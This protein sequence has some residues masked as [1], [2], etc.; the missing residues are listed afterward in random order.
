MNQLP[1]VVSLL[2]V[3]STVAAQTKVLVAVERIPIVGADERAF[4][5]AFPTACD[6]QGR[7]YVKLAW[8][9]PGN[10][11]PLLRLSDKGAV[12]VQFDTSGEILNRYAVRP[13]GGV[14]MMHSD[15]T[16]L[17]LATRRI[18]LGRNLHLRPAISTRLQ[19][20]SS[21]LRP[22]WLSEATDF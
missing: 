3:A 18:P 17:S 15:G 9:E 13:D 4:G 11:E 12:E 1:L 20:V 7:A 6:Q 14:V 16:F 5:I 22:N 2:L 10:V 21:D 19:I 8:S